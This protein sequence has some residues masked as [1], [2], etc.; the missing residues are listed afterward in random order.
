MTTYYYWITSKT[1]KQNLSSISLIAV[2]IAVIFPLCLGNETP[3]WQSNFGQTVIAINQ[4]RFRWKPLYFIG[5][6]LVLLLW[7]KML[8]L[9]E[10]RGI[11]KALKFYSCLCIL[12]L[13]ANVQTGKI[14]RSTLRYK[15]LTYYILLTFH[16]IVATYQTRR[17]IQVL[18]DNNLWIPLH[19][20]VHVA[21]CAAVCVNFFWSFS[22]FVLHPDEMIGLFNTLF[23]EQ[24]GMA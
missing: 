22:A 20:P 18:L 9:R 19:F 16:G 13:D 3:V 10:G 4:Y 12:P 5:N 15:V 21:T 24:S 14:R 7:M 11:F 2:K 23:S 8:T 17:L 6:F 1:G